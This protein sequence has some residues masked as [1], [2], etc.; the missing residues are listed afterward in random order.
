VIL[1]CFDL[2]HEFPA[3][4]GVVA[5]LANCPPNRERLN[6]GY[7]ALPAVDCGRQVASAK[8]GTRG[9]ADRLQ[10]SPKDARQFYA[11]LR[12]AADAEM[13]YLSL[14]GLLFVGRTNR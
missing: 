8:D 3:H 1:V 14:H 12:V 4:R 2:A 6:R 7:E 11:I 13:I 10:P 9:E 5:Q